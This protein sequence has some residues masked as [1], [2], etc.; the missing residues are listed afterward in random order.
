MI[1]GVDDDA[2]LHANREGFEHAQLRP[3]RLRDTTKIDTQVELFGTL[4]KSPIF[5]CPTG[6]QKSF[7]PDGEL[8]V[9]R[10]ARARGAVQILSTTNSTPIEEVN[11]ALGRPV[12]FQLYAPSSWEACERLLRRVEA[13]GGAR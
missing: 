9:A 10:A 6:G 7:S 1:S 5:T 8:A 13:S 11:K 2:T 12:W 4:Y 3:R